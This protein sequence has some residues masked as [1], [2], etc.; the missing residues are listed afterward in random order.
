[1]RTMQK[2][3]PPNGGGISRISF[4]GSNPVKTETME[5]NHQ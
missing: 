4:C 5:E 3:S 1:M 2:N